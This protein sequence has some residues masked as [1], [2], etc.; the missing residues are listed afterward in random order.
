M[1]GLTDLIALVISAFIIL[2]IVV[3]IREIGY[4]VISP[5]VGVQNP[6]LTIGSGPR[7]MKFWIFDIRKYYHLYSWYSYDSLKRTSRFSYV[8]LYASPILVNVA[9]AVTINAMLANGM[10]QDYATFWN[11]FVFYVFY[12]VLFDAVPMKTANGKPNNGMIIYEMLRYGRRTD[13]NDEPFLPSTTEVEEEYQQE[14]EKVEEIKEREVEE[15]EEK[16]EEIKELKEELKK[17]G[18]NV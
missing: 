9:V 10:L 4:L 15:K 8:A 3:F 13:Y 18:K 2:P 17:E 16:E 14:M 11:R 1:F 5:I 6:R 12:F 7:I